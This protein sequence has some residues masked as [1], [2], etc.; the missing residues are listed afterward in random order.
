MGRDEGRFKRLGSFM[1]EDNIDYI[2]V[3]DEVNI[4]YLAGSLVD[5][6]ACILSR[7]GDLMLVTPP[8]EYERA[9]DVSWVDVVYRYG[10]GEGEDWIK[11]DDLVKAVAQIV[12]GRVGLPY[13]YVTHNLFERFKSSASES[14]VVDCDS[15][16]RKARAVKTR[17]EL[18]L[19][20]RAVDLVEAGIKNALDM[21]DVGITE[22]DIAKESIIFFYRNNADRVYSGLIV[23]SGYRSAY[24]HGRASDKKLG[25]GEPVTLDYV[26]A[27][28]GYWGDVTR[29]FFLKS[30]GA[31]IRRVYEVVEE[32]LF[33]AIDRVCSGV[34]AKEVDGV[35]R[36][37]IARNGYKEYFIHSTG[38]GVGLEV[39][40]SPRL[41]SKSSDTLEENMVITIEPGIYIKD[42]GGVRI[43]NDVVVTKSGVKVLN[44]LST[45]L[46][47]I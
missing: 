34:E 45:D 22:L 30:V 46:T 33:T 20:A 29:T 36:K 10:S 9:K 16:V 26:A 3:F 40:E 37:V 18:G 12:E 28:D 4:R 13:S 1:E 7:D 15:I 24:P 25:C 35:A 38:H 21:I 23:A 31:E 8:M 17:Y 41:S 32:A 47:V 2:V 43:E 39:H 42:L 27:L 19:L 44:K 14:V 11:A 6:S 5:Y